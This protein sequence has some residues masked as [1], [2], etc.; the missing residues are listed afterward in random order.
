LF[1]CY[2]DENNFCLIKVQ[3]ASLRFKIMAGGTEHLLQTV[4]F[5]DYADPEDDSWYAWMHVVCC[6][7]NQGM[8]IYI[9]G[10][11]AKYSNDSGRDVPVSLGPLPDKFQIGNK[12]EGAGYYMDSLMDELRIYGYQETEF[13]QEPERPRTHGGSDWPSCFSAGCHAVDTMHTAHFFGEAGP[14]LPLDEVGC[15][16][17]HA[18]GHKQ[19]RACGPVFADDYC[20]ENTDVC[21]SCHG[22]GGP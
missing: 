15:Y 19:C 4:D 10:Q 22:G 8:R 16:Y 13:L 3:N 1:Y 18:D 2:T 7:G 21:G 12:S 6:W 14:D 11:E 9:N 5:P 17:C 20:I